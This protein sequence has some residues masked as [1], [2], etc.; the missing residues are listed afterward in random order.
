[1]I[2]FFTLEHIMVL[3]N[4]LQDVE[5]NYDGSIVFMLPGGFVLISKGTD[6]GD[7]PA[8]E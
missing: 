8:L 5:K 4:L 3:R 1:M 7:G 6:G 2:E